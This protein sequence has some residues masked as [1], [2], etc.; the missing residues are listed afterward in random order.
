MRKYKIVAITQ[1][2]NEIRKGHLERFFEYLPKVVDEIVIYD[3]AS[4]DGSWQYAKKFTKHVLR[5]FK[6]DFKNELFHKKILLEKALSLNADF[7]LSID[8]DEVVTDSDGSK[9]QELAEWVNKN[10]L[11]GAVLRDINLWRSV[12]WARTDSDFDSARFLRFWKVI[13]G[14]AYENINTGLHQS[15]APT[16]VKKIKQTDI[17]SLL[18]FGFATD[19]SILA[20]Y[21]TYAKHGQNG[22][23]LAR[24]IDESNLS[25]REIQPNIYPVGLYKK[26]L[27]PIA[28]SLAEWLKLAEILKPELLKPAVTIVALIYKSTDWLKFSY[29]QILKY[30]D[31]SDKELIF[32]ANDAAEDVKKYLKENYIP[33]YNFENTAE[34][35]QQWYINNVYR[36]WNYG[37]FQAKG[38][39]VLFVN[40]DMAFTPDWVEN[41]IAALDG[42]NCVVSRLVESGKLTSGKEENEDP[43]FEHNFGK[44]I[45]EFKEQDFQQFAEKIKQQKIIDGGAFMPLLIKKQ[46]FEKV[47]GYPEGNV[48][49]G[50]DIFKPT[51]AE[52]GQELVSG[53]IILMAKLKTLG[54]KHQTVYSSVSY[55]FQ[56][57]EMSSSG[58]D[59]PENEKVEIVVV[60]NSLTGRM[61]E[62]VL[63]DFLLEQLPHTTGVDIKTVGQAEN[64]E[65]LAEKYIQQNF[66]N[67][68]I[69]LQNASFID[70]ISANKF[71]VAYLQDNLRQMKNMSPQQE[72]NLETANLLVTNSYN[73]AA[74][75]PEYFF[76]VLPIGVDEK[77]F[78]KKDKTEARKQ[79]GLPQGKIGIF[80]GDLSEVKGWAE[81]KNL[82]LKRLDIFWLVVSKS[83]EQFLHKNVKMYN[84]VNQQKLASLYNCADFFIIG[85]KVETQ[86]LAAMEACFCDLPVVMRPVGIF[87]E[88]DV[89][90][91]K[92]CGVFTDNFEADLNKV[93]SGS[94]RPR[95]IMLKHKFTISSMLEKW[96]WLFSEIKV[97][98]FKG[99]PTNLQVKKFSGKIWFKKVVMTL[100]N[101][102]YIN[103]YFRKHLP[104]PIYNFTLGCWRA[105]KK[106]KK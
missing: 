25:L 47:G 26:D 87:S 44:F 76:R 66:P 11:D 21:L 6:N 50:S 55:H 29:S 27:K 98:S 16:T 95:E 89:E 99:L 53:D 77:L 57:G 32:V 14:L 45:E 9:L 1:I 82:I 15:P 3:D 100:T 90:D 69:I 79:E 94:F 42:N 38:D 59:I 20:K 63:W 103:V 71:S 106:F 83:D 64:F 70:L 7:I 8:A 22:Q 17:V 97:A 34:H 52:K 85:S 74:S 72:A 84:K 41:L 80:V 62:K 86:C 28:K 88:L 46:D 61:G 35:K 49:P 5:G 54:V 101:K 60:N 93:F 68:K 39:Y 43:C 37:G 18:H 91:R 73:T 78:N 102:N 2:H 30:T 56:E 81:I 23:N 33:H 104:T 65:I 10:N 96:W 4:S 24:L 13:P 19:R 51:I 92:L 40:S 105:L 58:E 67:T 12:N 31:M 75:Y 48:V 36:A